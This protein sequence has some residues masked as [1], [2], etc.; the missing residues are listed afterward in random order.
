MLGLPAAKA[1]M[2][3]FAS[4]RAAAK[5]WVLPLTIAC[6][7]MCGWASPSKSLD[8]LETF[9]RACGVRDAIQQRPRIFASPDETSW[10]EYPSIK[11]IPDWA[12]EWTETASVWRRAGSPT[13]VAVAGAGQDFADYYYYCFNPQ[14]IVTRVEREFRTAWGWGFAE[15]ILYDNK[16]NEEERTSRYFDT[17]DEHT[18]E[19]PQESDLVTPSEIFRKVSLL[20]FFALLSAKGSRP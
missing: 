9:A 19:P 11:D 15:T 1:P 13:L 17:K 16:G 2:A 18:I 3:I 12:S 6:C 8:P 7:A 10:H 14:G 4:R 20:P 5:I